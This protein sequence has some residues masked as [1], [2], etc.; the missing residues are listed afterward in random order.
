MA[1]RMSLPNLALDPQIRDV[2][3]AELCGIITQIRDN[4][5]RLE[6]RW[7]R[8]YRI[9]NCEIDKNSYSGRSKIFLAAARAVSETF[10]SA[11]ARDFFPSADNWYGIQSIEDVGDELKADAVKALFDHFFQKQMKLKSEALPFFRQLVIYGTSPAKLTFLDKE[12][13]VTALKRILD[14]EGKSSVKRIEKMVKFYYGPHFAPRDLFN[15]YVYPET[16]K[17]VQDA[18]LAFEDIEVTIGH[19]KEMSMK[20]M[21]PKNEDLG[22]V[23]ETPD[24]VFNASGQSDQHSDIYRFRRER[25]QRMGLS[26]DPSDRWNKLSN[27]RRNLSEIYWRKD[28]DDSGEKEWLVT[29]INDFH[30][31]RIQENPFWHKKKPFIVPRMLRVVNE[32]YGRGV[33][34][35]IDRVQYMMNDIVNQT[36][37]S[38]Q[39]EINPITIIDP[40]MVSFAN[41]IRAHPG[42]KWLGQPAGFTFTKPASVAAVGFSTLNLLQGYI[43]DFS[44]ANA[45]LQG[46]PAARGRGRA[47]NTASGMQ[48]LLAQGSAGI[49]QIVEDLEQQFGEPLMEMSYSMLEQFMDEK[50]IIRILGR[51]GAPLLQKEV[52]IE[53]IVGN[54]E[55]K[56]L[57]STGT[58]NRQIIGQ[59]MINFLNI[60]RG[61]PPQVIQ[62]LNWPWLSKQVW[63]E[64]LGLRNAE[65]LF[66]PNGWQY[67]VDPVLEFKFLQEDREVKVS[68]GDDHQQHLKQHYIDRASIFDPLKLE[69]WDKHIQ[70][71]IMAIQQI[72]QQQQQMQMMQQMAMMQQG[73]G[74]Q[75]AGGGPRPQNMPSGMEENPMQAL[76][77]QLQGGGQQ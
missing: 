10:V 70:D 4:R 11:I 8:F 45:A 60:A 67:S 7:Q 54:Y 26:A 63:T 23:Y 16:A 6:E 21:D 24:E 5:I 20:F 57:G 28:L 68:P 17:D 76:M 31:V 56:W 29:L 51:R 75:K 71:T 15:F 46:Q 39:F 44:G 33:M 30:V 12:S 50:I 62:Q 47:Q 77:A 3:Q 43:H 25:L 58:R 9:W 38:V 13:Q 37:D 55:F 74:Q 69:K 35:V 1:V 61:F 72:I 2:V 65:E 18:I 49:S 22:H 40:S 36:M 73:N 53:D 64:G 14:T 41:S 52:G 48:T 19:I 59:Q 34:E 66:N 32:F 27:D 42:A